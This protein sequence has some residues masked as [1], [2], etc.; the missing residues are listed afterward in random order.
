MEKVKIMKK[1]M[2]AIATVMIVVL[3][4]VSLFV[5]SRISELQNQIGQLQEQNSNLELQII[6]IQDQL[7]ETKNL[8]DETQSQ[9]KDQ[10]ENLGD[11]T[12]ELALE[13]QLR[14]YITRFEWVGDFNPM[15]GL[16]IS[17]SVV[18]NVRNN[19]VVDVSGLTLTVRLLRKGTLIEVGQSRGFFTQINDL[20]AGESREVTGGILAALDSFSVDT[21]VCSVLLSVRGIVLDEGTFNLS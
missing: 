3:L 17:Y 13:R 2:L 20:G 14:L 16:A 19:D 1:K 10:I 9:L 12:Y 4:V 5:Y 18:V 7:N 11:T 8:L 21:A 6:E 15:V